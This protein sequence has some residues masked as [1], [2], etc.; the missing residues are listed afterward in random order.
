MYSIYLQFSNLR[1][2]RCIEGSIRLVSGDSW[3]NF[4]RGNEADS[5]EV[6]YIE[7]ALS[8][9]R[10]EM[11]VSGSYMSVCG[12]Q[13]QGWTNEDAAVVC[14]ELGFTRLGIYYYYTQEKFVRLMVHITSIR[15]PSLLLDHVLCITSLKS[16]C[17]YCRQSQL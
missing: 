5:P 10:V 6:N 1:L 12:D 15:V 11:C 16:S 2:V 14:N 4:Y 17:T 3:Y 8:Q 9:G 7:D 13:G